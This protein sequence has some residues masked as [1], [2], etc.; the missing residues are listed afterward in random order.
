M[1]QLLLWIMEEKVSSPIKVESRAR[2]EVIEIMAEAIIAVVQTRKE[3]S[4][5]HV[6]ES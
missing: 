3:G 6:D 5:E 2:R 4:D 1:N